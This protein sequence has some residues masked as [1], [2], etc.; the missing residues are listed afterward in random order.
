MFKLFLLNLF[1]WLFDVKYF[2]YIEASK[3]LVV[4][5]T[6]LILIANLQINQDNK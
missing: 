6:S 4:V 1:I 5:I 2:M 3:V